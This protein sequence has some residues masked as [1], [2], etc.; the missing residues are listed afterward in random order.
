[1]ISYD[2]RMTKEENQSIQWKKKNPAINV[3]IRHGVN[4]KLIL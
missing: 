4:K 1:M 3:V 2:Y